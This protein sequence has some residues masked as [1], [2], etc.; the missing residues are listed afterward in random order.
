MAAS[1]ERKPIHPLGD[2]ELRELFRAHTLR[3]TR[4]RELI[5]RA[6]EASRSHPTAEDVF[7]SVRAGDDSLSLATIYNTLDAFSA[8]GLVQRLPSAS[9]SGPSR[10]DADRTPH[11]HVHLADGRVID[12]PTDL[13]DRLLAGLSP[14]LLAEVEQR[15]GITLGKVSIDITAAPP[16]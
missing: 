5:Y 8:A 4:Q 2:A 10:Y 6:L 9:P 3:C 16:A 7:Q 14:A 11:V 12:L 1:L 13:G 15:I